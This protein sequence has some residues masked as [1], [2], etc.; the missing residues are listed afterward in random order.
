[1]I[2]RLSCSSLPRSL[3]DDFFTKGFPLSMLSLGRSLLAFFALIPF[4]DERGTMFWGGARRDVPHVIYFVVSSGVVLSLCCSIRVQE[5]TPPP[6]LSHW[7]SFMHVRPPTPQR[8]G[9]LI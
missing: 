3:E 2:Y 1:M 8:R 7:G 4:R 5:T 9:G 6:P